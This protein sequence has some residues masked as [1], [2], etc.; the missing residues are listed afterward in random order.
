MGIRQSGLPNFRFL[1]VI[2]DLKIFIVARDDAKYILDNKNDDN[3][4]YIVGRCKKEIEQ[5][6]FIKA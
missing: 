1:N 6:D 2:D 4:K 5:E 3:F